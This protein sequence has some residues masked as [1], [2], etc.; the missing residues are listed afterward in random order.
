ME[1]LGDLVLKALLGAG[2]VIVILMAAGWAVFSIFLRKVGGWIP[3]HDKEHEDFVICDNCEQPTVKGKFT[4]DDVLLCPLCWKVC[5][6]EGN[7]VLSESIE[8][9]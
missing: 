8:R 9:A 3:E 1:W 2:F 7:E 6:A 4:D 5:I